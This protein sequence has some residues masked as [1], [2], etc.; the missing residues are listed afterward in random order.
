MYFGGNRSVIQSSA[1][2]FRITVAYFREISLLRG[3]PAGLV[4]FEQ[5]EDAEK[6]MDEVDG[7]QLEDGVKLCVGWTEK[8][9]C[10]GKCRRQ[11][12]F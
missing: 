5:R 4:E 8:S 7:R 12:I 9:Y 10:P 3:K 2:K 1:F 6:A 11:G